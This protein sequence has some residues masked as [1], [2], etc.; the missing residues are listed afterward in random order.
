MPK[1]K[2]IGLLGGSFN[3][4]HSGHVYISEQAITALDLD[5]VWWLVN[6][7]NPFKEERDMLPLSQRIAYAKSLNKNPAV[8]V[9]D[10]ERESGTRYTADTL[11]YITKHYPKV[12]F[13]WLMGDDL[14][15]EFH[16][17]KDWQKI[18][19]MVDIAVFP[20]TMT[21]K[22]LDLIPAVNFIKE[23]GK[24][25]YINISPVSFSA[26]EIRNNILDN[27]EIIKGMEND[28]TR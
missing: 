23:K 13:V 6:P 7:L 4:A 26:S 5:E 19:D 18:P 17:W 1:N 21:E 11:D 9:T 8:K 22:Q 15:P 25:H 16:L 2:K 27:K 28:K 3:P 10:L 14:L 24:W 20:R 12:D